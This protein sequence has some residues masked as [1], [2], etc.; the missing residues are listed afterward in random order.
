M[1]RGE[2]LH[3]VYKNK[4][5]EKQCTD[6]SEAEK[7]HGS[8]M[9]EK[10]HQRIDQIKAAESVEFLLRFK[11]GGCHLLKGKRQDQY[12]M[13]LIHPHRLVFRKHESDDSVVFIIEIIDY[14]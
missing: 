7:K 8:Q 6:A 2:D 11:I 3:I 4:K 9:A 12:A 10:I 1:I 14:H 13:Y 5:L